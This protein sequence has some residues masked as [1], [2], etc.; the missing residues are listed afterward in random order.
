MAAEGCRERVLAAAGKA[1]GC[2]SLSWYFLSSF[3]AKM[4]VPPPCDV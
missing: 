1:L 4:C 3:A 2:S